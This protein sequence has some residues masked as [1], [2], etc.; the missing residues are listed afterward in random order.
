MHVGYETLIK[1]GTWHLFT[2]LAK[3]KPLKLNGSIKFWW[4]HRKIQSDKR[5]HTKSHDWLWLDFQ[6]NCKVQIYLDCPN[7]CCSTMFAY[8]TIWHLDRIFAWNH[9]PH[10]IHGAFARLWGR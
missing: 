6:S 10:H 4:L 7:N 9:Q 5:I 1:N 2:L 3:W 8:C